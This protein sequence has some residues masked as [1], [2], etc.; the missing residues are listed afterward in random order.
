[1]ATTIETYIV[2]RLEKLERDFEEAE[3]ICEEQKSLIE[4]LIKVN[5]TL[6]EAFEIG[7]NSTVEVNEFGDKTLYVSDPHKYT[8]IDA[9]A[10]YGYADSK[11]FKELAEMLDIEI[12][13][14]GEN[15]ESE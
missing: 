3:R 9:N 2:E 8:R 1:M 11:E 4:Y 5:T 15:T 10:F 7:N 12:K 13:V 6:I 14:R